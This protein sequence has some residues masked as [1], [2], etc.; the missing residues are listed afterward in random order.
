MVGRDVAD[1]TTLAE[2]REGIS[3]GRWVETASS[4]A[5]ARGYKGRQG[6]GLPWPLVAG[7]G[8]GDTEK[9]PANPTGE[10]RD[11]HPVI[12]LTAESPGRQSTGI[13]EGNLALPILKG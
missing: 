12:G 6:K 3:E 4:T 8:S 7:G 2:A 11:I 1:G 5:P 10:N 13:L 9:T